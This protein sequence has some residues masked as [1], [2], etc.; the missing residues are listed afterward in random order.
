M[1]LENAIK[2]NII[3]KDKPLHIHIA[4][5][6]TQLC[7]SNNLQVKTNSI[8]S[9]GIGLKNIENRYSFMSEKKVVV[10]KEN[11]E[12]KVCVPLI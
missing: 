4:A 1:L 10:T 9:N 11:G 7:V 8:D 2:H 6:D 12:F 3:S 5:S